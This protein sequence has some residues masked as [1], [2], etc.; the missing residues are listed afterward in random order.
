[1]AS[2]GARRL[3]GHR[4]ANLGRRQVLRLRV[5]L[6]RPR[7]DAE[8]AAGADPHGTAML[9]RRATQLLRPRYRRSLAAALEQVIKMIDAPRHPGVSSAVPVL[10]GQVAQARATVLSLAQVLRASESVHPRGVAMVWRLLSDPASP[11]YF[12]TESGALER[13]AQ[14][15]LDCLVG[16][17][18]VS[19]GGSPARSSSA[20]GGS[21]GER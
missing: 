18:W 13:Q 3:Q 10:R 16:Q 7:L 20:L 6:S 11:L 8:L 5:W 12:S 15:A 21:D 19:S 9:E 17:P 1:V 2:T 4:F 14:V